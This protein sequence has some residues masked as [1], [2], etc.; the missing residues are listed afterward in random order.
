VV[1]VGLCT[2]I[3]HWIYE[4]LGELEREVL[5]CQYPIVIGGNFNLIRAASDKNNMNLNWPRIHKFKYA[6][7]TMYL[8]EVSRAG[9]HFTWTNKQLNL[10]HSVLDRVFVSPFWQARFP[11][12]SLTTITRVGLDHMPLILN[13]GEEAVCRPAG[14]MFQTW[15]FEEPDFGDLVLVKLDSFLA[16]LGPQRGSTKAWN[17]IAHNMR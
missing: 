13:S 12:Y 2:S 10:V 16:N 11:L 7:A 9:A 15:W 17:F 14:F 1:Y 3:P 4:F 5:A 6:I 8:R